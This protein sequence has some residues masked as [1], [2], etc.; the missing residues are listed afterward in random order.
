MPEH[1]VLQFPVQVDEQLPEQP[2][3]PL[4][5]V[6]LH[7]VQP[8]HDTQSALHVPVQWPVQPVPQVPTH[9][10]P[11]LPEHSV[12]QPLHVPVHE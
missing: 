11:Q 4:I 10:E 7:D 12:V 5:H 6:E 8:L 9:V 2:L 3:Q 1:V